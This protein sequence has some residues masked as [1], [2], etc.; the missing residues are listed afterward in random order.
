MKILG[1]KNYPSVLVSEASCDARSAFKKAATHELVILRV[2]DEGVP[3]F[4]ALY[5]SGAEQAVLSAG[6][7]MPGGFNA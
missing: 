4:V 3:L 5:A 7:V 2:Q 1:V 6:V